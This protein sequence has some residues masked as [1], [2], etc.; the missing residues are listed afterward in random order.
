VN[1]G[2]NHACQPNVGYPVVPKPSPET[3]LRAF[4]ISGFDLG[5]ADSQPGLAAPLDQSASRPTG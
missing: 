4:E 5:S 1:D 2:A 3:W